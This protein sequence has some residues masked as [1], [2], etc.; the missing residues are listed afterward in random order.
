LNPSSKTAMNSLNNYK[1]AEDAAL[2]KQL[3]WYQ[4]NR[5]TLLVHHDHFLLHNIDMPTLHTMPSGQK[6]EWIWHLTVAKLANTQEL[7]LMI[8][9]QHSLFRYM[10][11]VNAPPTANPGTHLPR[12][13]PNNP[14][15]QGEKTPNWWEHNTNN[16]THI[17]QT[18]DNPLLQENV[19]EGADVE[20]GIAAPGGTSGV[21]RSDTPGR[22]FPHLPRQWRNSQVLHQSPKQMG[23]H[24]NDFSSIYLS[25]AK[26]WCENYEETYWE[27]IYSL[28]VSSTKRYFKMQFVCSPSGN[29]MVLSA[30][31]KPQHT[32]V[33]QWYQYYC[34]IT[35]AHLLLPVTVIRRLPF[36]LLFLTSFLLAFF[37]PKLTTFILD[38]MHLTLHMM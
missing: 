2:T 25:F 33:P 32:P 10:I 15:Q 31:N 26:L 24:P 18:T 16:I 14:K 7:T 34:A 21:A 37:W 5:H 6:W 17:P 12:G 38:L 1:R 23:P 27:G 35:L 4:S 36:T 28:P 19:V 30:Q 20:D 29:R 9:N 8:T 13:K 22:V 3:E 11:P